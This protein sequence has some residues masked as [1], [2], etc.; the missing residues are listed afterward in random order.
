MLLSKSHS[1]TLK[2]LAIVGVLTI[3]F[4]ASFKSSPY[5]LSTGYQSWA[6]L[7]DQFFR[8]C[9]P[10]FILISGYGL[11]QKYKSEER[12]SYGQFLGS[13][14]KKLLPLY[15]GWSGIY[16]LVFW[17]APWWQSSQSQLSF[18]WQLMLGRADYHLYF[19][20]M[21][22]QLYALFPALFHMYRRRPTLTVI[23]A[24]LFQL[25]WFWLFVYRDRLPL[26]LG[27]FSGD[28]EHYFWAFNWIFYFVF[29][30]HIERVLRFF[31]ANVWHRR[32]L[33]L[34]VVLSLLN[35]VLRALISIRSGVDPLP[36]LRFT[37]YSTFLY[38]VIAICWFVLH[39][40]PK[41]ILQK[42]LAFLGKHSYLLYLSHT[43]LLRVLF[44]I[45]GK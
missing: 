1:E 5:L 42:G 33:H 29:G 18:G 35:L 21:L 24:G 20:P 4:L 45:L 16:F 28:K 31:S 44:L 32:S 13:R 7:L 12:V 30:M 23:G 27:F 26:Q 9:V 22:L 37:Q 40:R 34:L 11:M 10:L 36:V 2:G 6:V 17:L 19:V 15:V 38:A 14:L 39:F 41:G 43:L 8:F 3:H 25:T